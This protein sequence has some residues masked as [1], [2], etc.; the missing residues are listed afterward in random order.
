MKAGEPNKW[1]PYFQEVLCLDFGL[2]EEIEMSVKS[3]GILKKNLQ[4][5]HNSNCRR[6]KKKKKRSSVDAKSHGQKKA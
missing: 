3:T 2:F 1:I 5:Y 6:Q 4:Q